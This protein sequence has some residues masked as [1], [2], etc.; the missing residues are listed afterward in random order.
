M[1]PGAHRLPGLT[2]GPLLGEH[3]ANMPADAEYRAPDER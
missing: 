2:Q 3:A 1:A